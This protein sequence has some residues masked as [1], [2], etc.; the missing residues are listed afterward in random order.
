[1]TD[2]IGNN[3]RR[4]REL[5]GFSQEYMAHELGLTQSSYGK[6]E[7]EAVKLTIEKLQRIA[8][9]LEVDLANLI[10]TKNQNIFNM[11]NNQTANGFIEHQHLETKEAYQKVIQT[12]E[13]ENAHLKGEIVYLRD[14]AKK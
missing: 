4:F 13:Q 1:M 8:E 5:R 12:L 7:R 10:N 11:Y 6:I 2:K 3:I 14:L 9:I